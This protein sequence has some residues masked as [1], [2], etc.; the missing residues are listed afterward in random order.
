MVGGR[1][2]AAKLSAVRWV[3]LLVVGIVLGFA[4]EA[5][6][7]DDQVDC[8]KVRLAFAS[9]G[10]TIICYQAEVELLNGNWDLVVE[11]YEEVIAYGGPGQAPQLRL[12]L[13][14]VGEGTQSSTISI[15]DYV[16]GQPWFT[17]T[18]DWQPEIALEGY[19]VQLLRG[20]WPGM[21]G[22]IHCAALLRQERDQGSDRTIGGFFC[23]SAGGDYLL[24]HLKPFL[25]SIRY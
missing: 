3:V 17:K 9:D 12:K 8:S 1:N 16:A 21:G 18:V 11:Q 2:S 24:A 5:A 19:R 4:D 22:Y 10:Y 7:R 6:A 20:A 14:R 13:H 15:K 25:A 23:F